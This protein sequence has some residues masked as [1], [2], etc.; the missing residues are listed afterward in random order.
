MIDR[1]YVV[2]HLRGYVIFQLEQ[3]YNIKDVKE[4]L[5]GYGYH[6]GL[7][8]DII[9]RVKELNVGVKRHSK[10]AM[11][12]MNKDLYCYLENMLIDFIIKEHKQGYS[13]IAIKSAL[14]NYGHHPDMVEKA[15]KAI[16][17]GKVYDFGVNW[18]M[19]ISRHILFSFCLLVVFIFVVFVSMST[20]VSIGT[21]LLSFCPAMI[22]LVLVDVLLGL[23][24]DKIFRSFLPFISMLFCVGLFVIAVQYFPLIRQTDTDVLIILNVGIAFVSALIITFLSK[25]ELVEKVVEKDVGVKD[26][27]KFLAKGDV[28]VKKEDK[29]AKLVKPVKKK[30]E[31][32]KV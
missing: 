26:A 28:K 31:L 9:G 25:R 21:V 29:T 8:D 19:G 18:S 20:N 17:A 12:K 27:V 4:V 11:N 14:I 32:K 22:T 30:V 10:A 7:V 13:L 1:K 15:V 2:D 5:L 23:V 16:K 24:S 3:G 6:E